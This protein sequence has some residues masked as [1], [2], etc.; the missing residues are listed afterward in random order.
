MSEVLVGTDDPSLAYRFEDD[1]SGDVI[2]RVVEQ[3]RVMLV[4]EYIDVETARDVACSTDNNI[5]T[6][7]TAEG[8]RLVRTDLP[9]G[10]P[11]RQ[12]FYAAAI[13]SQSQLCPSR[14]SDP[15]PDRFR[16]PLNRHSHGDRSRPGKCDRHIECDAD[17]RGVADLLADDHRT[18][19]TV[20]RGGRHRHRFIRNDG[21]GTGIENEGL[22]EL[23][24]HV[25]MGD[26]DR[27]L[28]EALQDEQRVVSAG[29]GPYVIA[30]VAVRLREMNA[31]ANVGVPIADDVG[32]ID[33]RQCVAVHVF[34][35][36]QGRM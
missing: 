21:E 10:V 15:S 8:L 12:R 33:L 1:R 19:L 30:V 5:A 27:R 4:D 36:D 3:T 18:Q 25:A 29:G 31:D 11:S 14:G 26:Q 23:D 28:P 24:S 6:Q 7:A 16:H 35:R 32:E 17:D 22:V 9:V 13:F 20:A 2:Q 34:A